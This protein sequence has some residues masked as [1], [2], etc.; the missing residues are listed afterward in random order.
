MILLNDCARCSGT[1][2]DRS[3][4]CQKREFCRRHVAHLADALD[5]P[6]RVLYTACLPDG[7]FANYWPMEKP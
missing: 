7:E 3:G 6:P 1:Y 2:L 4:L 5:P